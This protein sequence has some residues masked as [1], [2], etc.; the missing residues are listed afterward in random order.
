MN[1]MFEN[2]NVDFF[3]IDQ[4]I[5]N[6]AKNQ[7]TYLNICQNRQNFLLGDARIKMKE[8]NNNKYDIIV[9]DAF[10]SD[11]IPVHLITKEAISM[12]RE[13]LK[14]N[15]LL[16]FHISNRYLNLEPVLGNIAKEINIQSKFCHK[17]QNKEQIYSTG[18]QVVIMSDNMDFINNNCWNYTKIDNNNT[19]NDNYSNILKYMIF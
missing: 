4:E 9:V 11:A 16:V 19:W 10:S 1:C 13:K 14:E 6:I 18:S 15:G 8:I 17:K 3:E 5:I 2:K 7:F 12:Y